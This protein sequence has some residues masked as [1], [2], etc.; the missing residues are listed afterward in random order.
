MY[1]QPETEYSD[2]QHR[3]D[4][5]RWCPSG[6]R[7]IL[8]AGLWLMHTDAPELTYLMSSIVSEPNWRGPRGKK[9]AARLIESLQGDPFWWDFFR[10]SASDTHSH[11]ALHVAIFQEPFLTWVFEGRKR[12]E[13]RFSHHQVAPYGEVNPG[14]VIALKRVGGP[15]VGL[16]LATACW[17]YRLDAKIWCHIR[18]HFAERL[19]AASEEFWT[20]RRS[21]RFVT[22]ISID[23]VR[24]VSDIDYPKTD[25]R[26]WVIERSRVAQQVMD[27]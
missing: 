1:G 27:L 3:Q 22:L 2:V 4:S 9:L 21:A 16:C 23:H 12:V 17:S 10:R 25:R 24:S 14:D 8:S 15:I 19:C 5:R 20:S 11:W 18:D 26:G 13:S 6:K 7:S